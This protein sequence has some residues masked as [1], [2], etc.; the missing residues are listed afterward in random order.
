MAKH[1]NNLFTIKIRRKP[2]NQQL[3]THFLLNSHV[4]DPKRTNSQK[5]IHTMEEEDL[6]PAEQ[7]G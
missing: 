4:P 6:L 7:K 5:N 1:R 2:G 3:P